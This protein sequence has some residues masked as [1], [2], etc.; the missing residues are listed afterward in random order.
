MKSNS[1]VPVL[2]LII[3]FSSCSWLGA[4][5]IP[6][7]DNSAQIIRYENMQADDNYT[8]EWVLGNTSKGWAMLIFCF[9]QLL[10]VSSPATA[11]RERKQDSLWTGA[12]SWSFSVHIRTLGLTTEFIWSSTWQIGM[13]T[14]RIW[15][16]KITWKMISHLHR[17]PQL[18]SHLRLEFGRM[19]SSLFWGSSRV[20]CCGYQYQCNRMLWPDMTIRAFTD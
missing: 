2:G 20:L 6:E 5:P 8:F 16:L 1:A 12:K 4:Q 9:V 13:D 10:S 14:N 19:R 15:P 3:V 7:S 11:R 17:Y 18:E